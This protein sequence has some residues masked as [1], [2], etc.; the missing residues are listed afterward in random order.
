MNYIPSFRNN[1]FHLTSF[2]QTI[3]EVTQQV[4]N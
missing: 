4:V 1:L 2:G 3:K